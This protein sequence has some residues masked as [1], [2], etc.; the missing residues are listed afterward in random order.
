MTTTA[1][2]PLFHLAHAEMFIFITRNEQIRVTI[3]ATVSGNMH[4]MT[5]YGAA[6]TEIDL[7]DRMAFLAVGFNTKSSF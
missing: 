6:G 7:L 4:R 1:G 3:F 2:F 5:E